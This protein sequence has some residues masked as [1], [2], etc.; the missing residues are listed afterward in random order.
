M[1]KRLISI[2][3]AAV[4][5]ISAMQEY[6]AAAVYKTASPF[7]ATFIQSWL[8]R[9][10]SQE[11]W[12]SELSAMKDAGFEALII[13]SVCEL[14]YEQTDTS[15]SAQD[16]SNYTLSSSY[17]LYP[18]S[19]EALSSATLSVQNRG[20]VLEYAFRAAKAED[21]QIYIGLASDDRW[22]NYGWGI[23][24]KVSSSASYF[25]LW[26]EENGQLCAELIED[27]WTRYGET[28][29]DCIAGW[30]YVNEIWNFDSACAGT[31]NGEYAQIIGENIN[32]SIEKINEL[33]PEKPL[34]ISPF[35]NE[36]LSTAEQ[37]SELWK[38][39]FSVADFRSGDIF[40]HQDG[41]GGEKP[42][43]VI[44]EFAAALKEAVSTE[45]G[46]LFYINNET[47]QTD[48]SS[49]SISLLR[50]SYNA[51]ADLTDSRI[52]FSWNHY[53]NPLV[54]EEFTSLNEDFKAFVAELSQKNTILTGD[55][56]SD[57]DVNV[58]DLVLLRMQ[59]L[60]TAS[61]DSEQSAIA[62][63]NT[64]GII[65]CFDFT[66]LRQLVATS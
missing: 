3:A 55:I 35:F 17:C 18:S 66:A 57:G 27:I 40:A 54:N 46:L 56:N 15:L 25:S 37:Y 9:D 23:P 42:L 61:L 45:N 20:D 1:L 13:Q 24:E 52:L 64:D 11:R 50:E 62:D 43:D 21:M 10:W 41:S 4:L 16:A 51:T 60:G 19:A 32:C 38:D 36:T 6:N 34:M 5:G 12:D 22:W 33:C 26:S 48:F 7:K 65:D 8:C 49:K 44:R 30:Y 47:F 31:D 59:L 14:D 2:A 28:Y 29:G 58:A 63:I 53:Y 39:I